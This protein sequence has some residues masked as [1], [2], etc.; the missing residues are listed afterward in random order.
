[1]GYVFLS[2]CFIS[3]ALRMFALVFFS[4]ISVATNP[5]RNFAHRATMN[6]L[7]MLGG[8][9]TKGLGPVSAGCLAALLLFIRTFLLDFGGCVVF[10]VIAGFASLVA[11]QSVTVLEHNP[12]NPAPIKKGLTTITEPHVF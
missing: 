7:S 3:Y 10:A 9:A 2:E 11:I 5:N 8:S 4:S 6:G 1:M 12:T